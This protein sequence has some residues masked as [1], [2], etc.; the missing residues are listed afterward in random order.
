MCSRCECF[1]SA[2]CWSNCGRIASPPWHHPRSRAR[3]K[4]SSA[5]GSELGLRDMTTNLVAPTRIPVRCGGWMRWAAKHCCPHGS[6]RCTQP[7][8]DYKPVLAFCHH[9]PQRHRTCPLQSIIRTTQT[10]RHCAVRNCA[11]PNPA[12]LSF[13]LP[14]ALALSVG[15]CRECLCSASVP[16]STTLDSNRYSNSARSMA[17]HTHSPASS[18]SFVASQLQPIAIMLLA[19]TN[20]RYDNDREKML[21]SR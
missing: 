20:Y 16:S 11:W 4:P 2:S 18:V 14:P 15:V 9:W 21:R 3:I 5:R 8:T 7:I 1:V 17:T 10:R 12:S 6:N 13:A 19:V